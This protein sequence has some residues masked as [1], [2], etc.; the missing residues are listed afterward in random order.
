MTTEERSQF[1]GRRFANKPPQ[2]A[3]ELAFHLCVEFSW[4]LWKAMMARNTSP[5]RLAKVVGWPES[6]IG[7]ILTVTGGLSFAD[8]G[9]VCHALGL[10]VRLVDVDVE[11]KI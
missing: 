8:V 9:T 2:S 5:A 10:H 4:I 6:K 11:D 1:L 3:E 7:N